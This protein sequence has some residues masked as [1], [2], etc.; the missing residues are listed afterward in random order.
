M[1]A[2]H[3]VIEMFDVV[4][5]AIAVARHCDHGRNQRDQHEAPE[6]DPKAREHAASLLDSPP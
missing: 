6:N 5:L 1:I 4:L 3:L 2:V